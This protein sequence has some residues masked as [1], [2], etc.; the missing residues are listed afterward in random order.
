MAN[1][2]SV[3][4]ARAIRSERAVDEVLVVV[5]IDDGGYPLECTDRR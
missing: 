5:S 1:A 3:G 4:G 2:R